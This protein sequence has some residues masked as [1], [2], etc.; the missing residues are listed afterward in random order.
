MVDNPMLV[1]IEIL[2]TLE[3]A[4]VISGSHNDELEIKAYTNRDYHKKV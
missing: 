4:V 1:N 3:T 2:Q